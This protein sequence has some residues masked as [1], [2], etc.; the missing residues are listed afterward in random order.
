MTSVYI[1]TGIFVW[2]YRDNGTPDTVNVSHF[3][4]ER[5]SSDIFPTNTVMSNPV[6][7]DA[8]G[9]RSS[10]ITYVGKQSGGELSA[11]AQIIASHDGAADDQKGN[12]KIAVNASADNFSPTT[13]IELSSAGNI[14]LG[15]QAAL[16]TNATD[17]FAYIPTCAGAPTGV[18]TAY[19]GK[20]AFIYDTTDDA[21]YIYDGA[22]L[23]V[24]VAA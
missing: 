17:G 13:L 7:S 24:H 12:L 21:L 20:V 16:A 11:L 6:A 8:A 10:D 5:L 22:W 4:I 1:S 3:E 15:K 9:D 14:V 19:T 23:H 2:W 18:P